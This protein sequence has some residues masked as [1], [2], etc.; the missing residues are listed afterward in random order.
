MAAALAPIPAPPPSLGPLVVAY[1]EQHLAQRPRE[2]GGNNRG[3]W[4]RLYMGGHDGLEWK[5]CAGFA[6]FCLDQ[7]ARTLGV[8]LPLEPSYSCAQLGD[9]ARAARTLLSGD[10]PSTPERVVPGSLFLIRGS[11][12]QWK[13]VGIV[14][15]VQSRTFTTIEGNSNENGSNDGYEVCSNVRGW[16]DAQGVARDFIVVQRPQS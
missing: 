2:V 9:R 6:C 16:R 4:V 3:P 10:D 11:S 14:R 15:A 13:H 1:A 12:E 7:A 8:A 5:W